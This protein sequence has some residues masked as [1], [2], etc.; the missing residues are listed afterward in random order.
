MIKKIL[1]TIILLVISQG[2]MICFT[3]SQLPIKLLMLFIIGCYLT[4]TL[5]FWAIDV[6]KG[7]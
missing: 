5:G 4:L 2:M 7:K 6:L 1:A 3:F